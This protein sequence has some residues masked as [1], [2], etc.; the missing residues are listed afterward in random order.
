MAG[1]E[2]EKKKG[3]EAPG[4]FALALIFFAWFVIMY[5]VAWMSLSRVW[6]VR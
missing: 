4:T 5:V 2:H 1:K 6:P 3:F